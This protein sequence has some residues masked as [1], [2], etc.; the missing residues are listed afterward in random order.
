MIYEASRIIHIA[1]GLFMSESLAQGDIS[2]F[3]G[4]NFGI[5]A[6]E[7]P[8]RLASIQFPWPANHRFLCMCQGNA[9]PIYVFARTFTRSV[10]VCAPETKPIKGKRRNKIGQAPPP[11]AHIRG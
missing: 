9:M 1:C 7:T 2:K 4:E 3:R 8:H 6:Q 11:L 10:C 5:E